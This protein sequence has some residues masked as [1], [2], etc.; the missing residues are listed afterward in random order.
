MID[1]LHSFI[2]R[3]DGFVKHPLIGIIKE[4][5]LQLS[6]EQNPTSYSSNNRQ[7]FMMNVYTTRY[8]RASII[9]DNF[10]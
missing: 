7:K 6:F 2:Y 3:L 10:A 4:T 1:G 8:S 9:T 5:F